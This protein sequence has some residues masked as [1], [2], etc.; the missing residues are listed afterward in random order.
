M[1][2]EVKHITLIIQIQY[3]TSFISFLQTHQKGKKIL[4]EA[5]VCI[6]ITSFRQFDVLH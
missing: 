5:K 3:Y 1:D 4:N 2:D 6:L